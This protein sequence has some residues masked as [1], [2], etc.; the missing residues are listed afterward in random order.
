MKIYQIICPDGANRLKANWT[1]LRDAEFD[2][3]YFS[4][5]SSCSD[6]CDKAIIKEL[7][8]CN[9]GRHSINDIKPNESE[10]MAWAVD[11]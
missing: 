1:N 10:I 6:W 2:A 9:G 7:G 3:T 5:R 8:Y 4:R 11:L